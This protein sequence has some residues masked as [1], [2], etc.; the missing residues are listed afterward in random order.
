MPAKH[1]PQSIT[2]TPI[3]EGHRREGA[4]ELLGPGKSVISWL[5]I[6]PG[7]LSSPTCSQHFPSLELRIPVVKS[8]EKCTRSRLRLLIIIEMLR[9]VDHPLIKE[10]PVRPQVLVDEILEGTSFLHMEPFVQRLE[11]LSIPRRRGCWVNCCFAQQDWFAGSGRP[12]PLWS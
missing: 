7:R 3:Q 9:V 2:R 1:V 6:I 11:L 8:A 4:H 5:Q 12:L 10:V